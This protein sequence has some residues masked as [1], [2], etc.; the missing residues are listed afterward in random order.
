[1]RSWEQ[2]P[3]R[4]NIF[5]FVWPSFPSKHPSFY[6]SHFSCLSST[7]TT[8]CST[9]LVFTVWCSTRSISPSA[10]KGFPSFQTLSNFL[11]CQVTLFPPSSVFI[12]RCLYS[13]V[14]FQRSAPFQKWYYFVLGL[15]LCVFSLLFQQ[16]N[17]SVFTSDLR[18]ILKVIIYQWPLK[19]SMGSLERIFPGGRFIIKKSERTA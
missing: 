7:T 1:M 12:W 19:L 17:S 15:G 4:R 8:H 10:S 13:A 3:V 9:F 14:L 2:S 18:Y 6:I 11:L 16:L 5:K